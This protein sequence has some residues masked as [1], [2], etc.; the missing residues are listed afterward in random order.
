M[1][2]IPGMFTMP[3]FQ[4]QM[5]PGCMQPFSMGPS[6]TYTSM[7]SPEEVQL[8]QM[9]FQLQQLQYMKQNL[10]ESLEYVTKSTTEV[11]GAIK[12]LQATITKKTK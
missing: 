11:E 3:S 5:P 10:E 8:Q 9:Q 7:M 4:H 6:P 1:S 12:K 2:A